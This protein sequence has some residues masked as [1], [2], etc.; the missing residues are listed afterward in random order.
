MVGYEEGGNVFKPSVGG[1]GGEA[2]PAAVSSMLERGRRRERG[3]GRED[4]NTA[5]TVQDT[6]AA[7]AATLRQS[8][9]ESARESAGESA[10]VGV[11]ASLYQPKVSTWGVFPRPDNISEAYGGGRTIKPGNWGTNSIKAGEGFQAESAA[12]Q[13]VRKERVKSR[14][15]KYREDQ[16]M[17]ITNATLV[18]WQAQLTECKTCMRQGRL[19]DG[20]EALEAIVL[21]EKVNPRTEIGGDIT[22]HYAM[23]L[24]NVQRRGEALEM[25]KRC[26]GNP[27]GRISKQADQIIWGM[28][29]AVTKMK[30][31]QFEHDPIK[32]TYDPYLIKMTVNK[33]KEWSTTPR[34]VDPE[35]EESLKKITA[36]SIAFVVGL[37]L[38][39]VALIALR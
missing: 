8:A 1:W 29:T 31:N 13:A 24:D 6:D 10:E 34:A 7:E 37:P 15:N 12:E 14:L 4:D 26:I 33:S 18:R 35:E 22:F 19:R 21:E 2:A 11:D 3:L 20:V 39:L 30:A 25:Y 16:G 28:T 23:C 32:D 17:N 5:G 27:Y 36:A 38:T 9:G